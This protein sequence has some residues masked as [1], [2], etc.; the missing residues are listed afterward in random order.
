[1]QRQIILDGVF[2]P[3]Q[4]KS[5]IDLPFDMPAGAVR[6]DV[7]YSYSS[8]ISSDPLITGGNTVDLGV[9]DQRGVAF[10]RAGFRGSSGSERHSF[11]I[12]ESAA[13]PGYLAGPLLPGRWH[14]NLGLYK[15]MPD[16]CAYRVTLRSL[17]SAGTSPRAACR[18]R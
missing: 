9:F 3:E 17:P 1:M 8:Q 18:R 7:S 10:L 4:E 14:V 15:I 11:F 6:L 5:Y 12:T 16:G 2:R 13:T